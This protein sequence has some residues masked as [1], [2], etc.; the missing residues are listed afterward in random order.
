LWHALR[1]GELVVTVKFFANFRELTGRSQLTVEGVKTVG[2]L[3]DRLVREFGEGFAELVFDDPR[4]R[5]LRQTVNI[6]VNGRAVILMEGLET[7]LSDS[8]SVAIFP[9]VS[10]G[11][12]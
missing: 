3:L 6:L 12:E 5:K 9:P 8:D 1:G 10:G 4:T 7:K 11:R 2:E